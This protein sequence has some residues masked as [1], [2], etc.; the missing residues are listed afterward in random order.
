MPKDKKFSKYKELFLQKNHILNLI[1]KNDEKYLDEK[2]IFDSLAIKK[3][4]E[5][6][7]GQYR[8]LLD[9]GTGGGFPALPIAIEYPEIFVTGIDSIAKKINAISDIA[10]DLN[11]KNFNVICDRVEN[12]NDKNFDIITSRAVAKIDL[13]VKYAM[14]LL[15]KDGYLVIYKAKN[16][17][18]EIKSAELSLKKNKAKVVDIIEYKLPLEEI[19]ERNLVVIKH[20]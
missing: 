14:P 10:K 8:T 11:L 17:Q 12:I 1:S 9:I 13:I 6:Y 20:V 15:N 18:D 2:H 7:S 5:K 4:F 16:I 3:F 19:Y